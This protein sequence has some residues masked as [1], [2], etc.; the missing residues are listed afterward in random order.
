MQY[1]LFINDQIMIVNMN[2]IYKYMIVAWFI[3]N[4]TTYNFLLLLFGCVKMSMGLKK[5]QFIKKSLQLLPQILTTVFTFPSVW[6]WPLWHPS[7]FTEFIV[8]VSSRR[9]HVHYSKVVQ[10]STSVRSWNTSGTLHTKIV[11]QIRRCKTIT[12]LTILYRGFA[13]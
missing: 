1:H 3:Q 13:F 2:I 7:S 6:F 12:S 8:N 10:F 4:F 5:I 11:L 9:I